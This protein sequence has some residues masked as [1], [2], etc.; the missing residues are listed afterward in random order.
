LDSSFEVIKS[1]ILTKGRQEAEKIIAEAQK[2]AEEIVASAQRTSDEIVTEKIMPQVAITRRRIL[3]S[4]RLK[5]RTLM[6]ETK[7]EAIDKVFKLCE[8]RLRN[9]AAGTDAQY[10]YQ[11]LL[12]KLL[13]EAAH[14]LEE[15]DL[16]ITSDQNTLTYLK[17]NIKQIEET[18]TKNLGFQ[19]NLK[20]ENSPYDCVGGVVVR[21]SNRTKTFYNTLDGRLLTIKQTLTARVAEILFT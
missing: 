1:R 10:N 4:T 19:V 11:Q 15:H 18:M 17:N 13:C 6:L 3:A 14:R 8:E 2:K 16:V 12:I 21:N 20:I 7:S 5:G 9:V